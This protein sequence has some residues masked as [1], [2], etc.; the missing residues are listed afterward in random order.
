M[1]L[2]FS[3]LRVIGLGVL[4]D[5]VE[6]FT[7]LSRV[8]IRSDVT[9]APGV[10]LACITCWQTACI[11]LLSGMVTFHLKFTL[12]RSSVITVRLINSFFCGFKSGAARVCGGAAE[13]IMPHAISV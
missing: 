9:R 12:R 4:E 8:Q 10:R 1:C 3:I 11:N 13:Q 7:H 6:G 2:I 5:T